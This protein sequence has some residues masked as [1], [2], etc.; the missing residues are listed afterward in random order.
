MKLISVSSEKRHRISRRRAVYICFLAICIAVQITFIFSNS[1]RNAENS[2]S[3]STGFLR[4]VIEDIFQFDYEELNDD[5]LGNLHFII[6]KLAH[7]CEYA[8]LGTLVFL[9][10]YV[11]ACATKMC[12][13]C[14]VPFCFAIGM[15]DEFLQRFSEGRSASIAD[16]FLDT[17]GAFT[18]C[19]LLLAVIK[20]VR[21]ISHRHKL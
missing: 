4:F 9:L 17:S 19:A 12:F 16:A 1:L 6:R 15:I 10:M 18:A 7:F 13:Y 11:C 14:T 2:D 21:S 20:F 3:Q 5:F 8:M